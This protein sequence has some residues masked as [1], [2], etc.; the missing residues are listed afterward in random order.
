MSDSDR[1]DMVSIELTKDEA[2]AIIGAVNYATRADTSLRS[3]PTVSGF[4]RI[5]AGLREYF[6]RI[7]R[8]NQSTTEVEGRCVCGS[9]RQ[10]SYTI[11]VCEGCDA[12]VLE[13]YEYKHQGE[14]HGRHVVVE[15]VPRTVADAL[16]D[17]VDQRHTDK[18]GLIDALARYREAVGG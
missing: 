7:D 15:V 10:R 9:P 4:E 18:V 11:Y 13:T 5:Q 8:S 1:S 16:A 17:A 3:E 12:Q 6:E 2:A 14:G